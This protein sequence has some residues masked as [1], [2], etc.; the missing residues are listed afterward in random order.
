MNK[1]LKYFTETS[2]RKLKTIE[3]QYINKNDDLSLPKIMKKTFY[4]NEIELIED[5]LIKNMSEVLYDDIEYIN[6]RNENEKKITGGSNGDIYEIVSKKIIDWY[7]SINGESDFIKDLSKLEYV[8]VINIKVNELIIN[9]YFLYDEKDTAY[10]TAILY[11]SNTFF[12]MYKSENKNL[13]IYVCLDDHPRIIDCKLK[14]NSCLNKTRKKSLGL[15]VSGT[16]YPGLNEIFLSKKEEIIKLLFHELIHYVKLDEDCKNIKSKWDTIKKQLNLAEAFTEYLSVI[17]HSS[18]ISLLLYGRLLNQSNIAHSGIHRFKD[19][20]TL[21][22]IYLNIITREIN[23]SIYLCC[24]ILKIYGYNHNNYID[25]FKTQDRLNDQP[26]YLWEY[27]FLRTLIL[28]NKT[29]HNKVN[30]FINNDE[31]LINA[32]NNKYYWNVIDTSVSF[33]TCDVEWN[34]FY[35]NEDHNKKKIIEE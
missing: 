16:T 6:N 30:D 35:V 17:L 25:F 7:V 10:I 5:D 26:I 13:D 15:I 12:R 9:F 1:L 19:R 27:I 2:K 23:Y 28:L 33:L 29:K 18:Y 11:A 22:E 3:N 20:T 14:N 4:K 24:S 31:I 34:L 8:H 21:K 32:M